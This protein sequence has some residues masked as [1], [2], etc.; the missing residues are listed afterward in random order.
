MIKDSFF[1]NILNSIVPIS[2]FNKGEANKIFDEVKA[3]GFKV[4]LKNNTPSCVLLSPKMYEEMIEQLE[5]YRLILEAQ[6]RYTHAN[7]EQTISHDDLLKELEISS[8]DLKKYHDVEI[9]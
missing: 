3:S 9:E 4:V 5:D 1:T 2:R 7:I 8:D 6:E